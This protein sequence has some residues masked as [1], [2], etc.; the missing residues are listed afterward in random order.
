MSR[1]RPK[2][3]LPPKPI[4]PARA[5]GRPLYF[6]LGGT[7][8]RVPCYHCERLGLNAL[9]GRGEAYMNDPANSPVRTPQGFSDGGCYFICK[10]HTPDNAVIYDPQTGECHNKSGTEVW[11]EDTSMPGPNGT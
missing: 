4:A 1:R 5:D 8:D 2:L 3:I 11:R 6:D 10:G 9:H 7:G